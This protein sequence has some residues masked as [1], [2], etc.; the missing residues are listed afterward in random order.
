M[1]A[2]MS[3]EESERGR[4]EDSENSTE[5]TISKA[6]KRKRPKRQQSH[7]VERRRKE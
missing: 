2:N 3:K 6:L 4:K 7:V 1:R 5:R